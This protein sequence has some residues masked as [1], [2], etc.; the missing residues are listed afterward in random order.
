[1]QHLV[2][3]LPPKCIKHRWPVVWSSFL[4]GLLTFGA[5][6]LVRAQCA[7][8]ALPDTAQNIDA[9]LVLAAPSS[10]DPGASANVVDLFARFRCGNADAIVELE[11]LADSFDY[12]VSATGA[13]MLAG[14]RTPDQLLDALGKSS[15][16]AAAK[17]RLLDTRTGWLANET[18][19]SSR[20]RIVRHTSWAMNSTNKSLV[21]A[22]NDLRAL[23]SDPIVL[24]QRAERL[25]ACA[26]GPAGD[27]GANCL[28]R[29]EL[30]TGSLEEIRLRWPNAN[31]REKIWLARWSRHLAENQ[32]FLLD[33]LPDEAPV[34]QYEILVESLGNQESGNCA[35]QGALVILEQ[36]LAVS[37]RR[38]PAVAIAFNTDFREGYFG[39]D[40][41]AVEGS[42]PTHLQAAFEELATYPDAG[43]LM[44]GMAALDHPWLAT[45]AGI[46]LARHGSEQD[47]WYGLR[48]TLD[49]DGLPSDSVLGKL[50]S[51]D[52]EISPAIRA[53]FIAAIDYGGT[54]K[55]RVFANRRFAALLNDQLVANRV[56]NRIA[57]LPAETEALGLDTSLNDAIIAPLREERLLKRELRAIY[58]AALSNPID[59]AAGARYIDALAA[60]DAPLWRLFAMT[61]AT[62]LGEVTRAKKLAVSLLN[63]GSSKVRAEA[64][65]VLDGPKQLKAT[66][67]RQVESDKEMP[68]Q[69]S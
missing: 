64:R 13:L 14:R 25:M 51:Y 54:G 67:A 43:S 59:P 6:Q 7:D 8:M 32:R 36:A 30:H 42:Y 38:P 10:V 39:V 31:D 68:V 24:H 29:S 65:R 18:A 2:T 69:L 1:M 21:R 62:E 45:Q 47:A 33:R 34:V 40:A 60:L 57:H 53:L 17:T 19:R 22:A 15:M 48:F 9:F 52:D 27:A 35:I 50:L 41:Y 12:A 44:K 26:T 20:E 55:W 23:F 61:V 28:N 16:P 46:W 66:S 63:S 37:E 4:C 49:E 58:W 5:C 3:A 11:S 56:L